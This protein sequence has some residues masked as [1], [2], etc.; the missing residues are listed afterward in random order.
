MPKYTTVIFDLDGT[1]LNTLDDL[2]DSMN[3][4]LQ[5]HG[6]ATHTTDEI[7]SYVGNGIR[8]LVERAVPAG[9]DTALTDAVH[10]TFAEY[11]SQHSADKTRPYPGINDMLAHIRN[12]GCKTAVVSNKGHFAVVPLCERYFPGLLDIAIGEREGIRRKPYPDSVLEVMKQLGSSIDTT[13]YVGDSDV[14]IQTA[15]NAG[16]DCVAVDWGFR[17]AKFLRDS[18]AKVIVSDVEGLLR[19]I[20][21][22]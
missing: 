17:S 16:I 13:L 12:L 10:R 20:I 4:A 5:H 7:C 22:E 21:G 6:C 11:Y 15:Q 3:Y 14:D 2:A 8:N 9:S 19:E 1:I 18:G